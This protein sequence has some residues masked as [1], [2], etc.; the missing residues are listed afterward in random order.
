[1]TEGEV[2][3]GYFK[4]SAT[5][6]DIGWFY[7]ATSDS[8]KSATLGQ[9]NCT[10]GRAMTRSPIIIPIPNAD[11]IGFDIGYTESDTITITTTW[12][13]GIKSGSQYRTFWDVFKEGTGQYSA[14]KNTPKPFKWSDNDLFV[15]VRSANMTQNPGGGD[16]IEM[17]VT[18]EVVQ[19]R[20]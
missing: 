5:T 14:H 8:T 4:T 1:M 19:W 16:I 10:I 6:S 3:L 11:S 9:N 18:L 2:A 12:T 7:F 17:R 20:A 13:D 15:L